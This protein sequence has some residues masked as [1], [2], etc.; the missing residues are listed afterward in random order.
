MK[1]FSLRWLL[2]GTVLGAIIVA[3][4]GFAIYLDRVEQGNRLD[5]IDTE[6]VRAERAGTPGPQLD[7]PGPA[8]QTGTD[9]PNATD[10]PIQLLLSP[11]GIIITESGA[12]NPFSDATLT[13]LATGGGNITISNPRYRALR[14]SGQDAR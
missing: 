8:P 11:D 2:L 5:D 10:P 9:E 13:D 12:A 7:R 1:H 4:S 3:F 14:R 6:L